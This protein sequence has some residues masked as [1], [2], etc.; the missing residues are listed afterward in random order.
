MCIKARTRN[1][2]KA[3]ESGANKK[4]DAHRAALPRSRS[5]VLPAMRDKEKRGKE[6]RLLLFRAVSLTLSRAAA[7]VY[8]LRRFSQ[9]KQQCATQVPT[10]NINTYRWK[11]FQCIRYAYVCT[12]DL[13]F[14][15]DSN[16]MQ[17]GRFSVRAAATA[18][19]PDAQIIKNEF[20][21][22]AAP[23]RS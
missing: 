13:E 4:I 9:K 15:P 21:S 18:S 11:Y 22:T 19:G 10:L 16:N 23:T 7:A 8:P 17:I 12:N 20:T 2:I 3:R 14:Q 1:T 5:D 6:Q